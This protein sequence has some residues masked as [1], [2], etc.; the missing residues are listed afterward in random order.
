MTSRQA[1][2]IIGLLIVVLLGIALFGGSEDSQGQTP[3]QI[4][5]EGSVI[6]MPS[7]VVA[8]RHPTLGLY[9]VSTKGAGALEEDVK[10]LPPDPDMLEAMRRLTE[11]QPLVSIPASGEKTA[12]S[13]I[14]VAGKM[15]QLPPHVYV[16]AYIVSMSCDVKVSCLETPVYALKDTLTGI[17]LAVSSKTGR[18]GDP[19]IGQ[20]EMDRLKGEFKWLVDA[21]NAV[22]TPEVTK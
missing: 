13:M 21:V 7:G 1:A 3:G 5:G 22:E 2:T 9:A 20:E 11:G 16:E 14:D 12:G 8:G 6:T 15:I 19:A 4:L 10:D 17:T 18:M